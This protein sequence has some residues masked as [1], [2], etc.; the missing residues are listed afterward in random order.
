MMYH[1]Y[2]HLDVCSVLFNYYGNCKVKLFPLTKGM[3]YT[4]QNVPNHSYF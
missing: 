4:N 1:L 3:T 2:I